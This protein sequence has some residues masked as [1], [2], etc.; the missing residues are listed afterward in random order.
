MQSLISNVEEADNS[1]ALT[2][3]VSVLNAVNWIGLAMKKI[4]EE[5]VNKCFAKAGFGEGDVADNLEQASENIAAISIL[6]RRKELSCDTKNFVRSD[7]YLATHYSFESATAVLAVRNTQN[8][9][10]EEEGGG[11]KRAG[12]LDNRTSNALCNLFK[13]FQPS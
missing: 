7:A 5:T 13:L 9:D 8:E 4:K 1:Y 6:C 11:E 2:R 3:S 12:E 10:V